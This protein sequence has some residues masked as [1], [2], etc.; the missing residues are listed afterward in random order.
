MNRRKKDT[1]T[2]RERELPGGKRSLY[3]DIYSGGKRR[4]E[5]LKLYLVPELTRGDRAANREMLA[6]AESIRAQRLVKAQAEAF[7]VTAGQDGEA[8]FYDC[9]DRLIA[10]K[11]GTTKTSWE[12]CRA[13]LLRYH[14]DLRLRLADVDRTWVQGFRDYLDREASIWSIDGRKHQ[15]DARPLAEGTKALMF[16]KLCSLLNFAV[17]EGLMERNP[18]AAVERFKEP[19]SD[20]E[21]LTVDEMRRLARVPAPD[22]SIG[23]AF[24][25]SCL[26]GLRW[27]DIVALRWE[28]VQR[29][30]SVTRIVFTQQKTGGREYLDITDQAVALM[31]ARGSDGDLVFPHLGAVQSAR[32]KV[33]AWVKA[34]GIRK[35]ITFH[36]ARH[37]FAVMMLELG[38]DLY[39]LSKL[40]GHRSIETTQ[41]YA[42]ILDKTKQAA[43][44]RIPEIM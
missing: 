22:E 13:H 39:T 20:R 30:G 35:H 2:L 41:V 43:V 7:G 15:V 26:T 25:F 32:I 3:L 18:S 16:Q 21:F 29:I 28:S 14:S 11:E 23:R 34:A 38:T 33:A 31:G 9:L 4:Y 10:R 1:V 8:L 12:N 36:C 6:L 19:E 40:M 27:S 42:K 24:F 44:A 17:K 37:S 5:Y